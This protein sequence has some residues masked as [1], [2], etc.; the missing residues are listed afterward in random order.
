MASRNYSYSK[1]IPGSFLPRV[2]ANVWAPSMGQINL[3]KNFKFDWNL[4]K[5]NFSKQWHNSCKY[6]RDYQT[7][8]N[9][10]T[11]EGLTCH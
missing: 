7:S 3:K 10:I 1:K 9:K 5:K 11:L 6:E 2:V 8:R 4:C